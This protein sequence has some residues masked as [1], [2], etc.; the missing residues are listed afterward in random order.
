MCYEQSVYAI[1]G[2]WHHEF[3]FYRRSCNLINNDIPFSTW[4]EMEVR[5]A[6]PQSEDFIFKLQLKLN[7]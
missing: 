2:L 3:N 1:L 4:T 7:L 6:H 5:L